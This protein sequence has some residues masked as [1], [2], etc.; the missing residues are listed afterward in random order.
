[1]A[2]TPSIENSYFHSISTDFNKC[3]NLVRDR[4]LYLSQVS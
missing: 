1:M 2:A 4:A 3:H